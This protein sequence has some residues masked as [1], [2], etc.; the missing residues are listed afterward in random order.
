MRTDQFF[1]PDVGVG[2]NKFI[3]GGLQIRHHFC[4][5]AKAGN[6]KSHRLVLRY[7]GCA[8]NG[9]GHQFTFNCLGRVVL[10]DFVY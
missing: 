7:F 2:S 5:Q 9:F 6:H 10:A 4:G 3:Q 8:E 1:R